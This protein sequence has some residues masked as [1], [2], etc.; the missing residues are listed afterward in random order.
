MELT[1]ELSHS[2]RSGMWSAMMM[3]KFHEPVNCPARRLLAAETC[4]LFLSPQNAG[5]NNSTQ[6]RST[7][8]EQELPNKWRQLKTNYPIP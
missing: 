8:E 2:R 7:R 1:P 3:F 6:Q 4:S 5:G